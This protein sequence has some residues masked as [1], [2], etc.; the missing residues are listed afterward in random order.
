M[1]I[2]EKIRRLRTQHDMTQREFAKIAGVSDKTVSAWER[3]QKIPRLGAAKAIG[4]YFGIPMGDLLDPDDRDPEV[5]LA[6]SHKMFKKHLDLAL[7]TWGITPERMARDMAVPL[8]RVHQLMAGERPTEREF[9]TVSTYFHTPQSLFLDG[10]SPL[11]SD[12]RNVAPV[13]LTANAAPRIPVLGRVPAGIPIE[14]V[15]DV[16]EEIELPGRFVG[17]GYEYF[18]L[19]V[20]GES[21]FPEYRD[22]DVVIVRRTVTADTGD[23]VVAMVGTSDA[24][25]KRLTVMNNGITLRPLNPSFEELL[26]STD[27]IY[28]IPVTIAGIVVEQRRMRRR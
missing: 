6:E 25:L 4:T 1:S 28:S 23:D 11:S 14:A 19:L 2:G 10:S 21:M 18:A 8:A 3:D 16:I 12:F 27:E 26:F 5:V 22:G 9:T 13:T 24:T 17:D 7:T 15:T 20:T